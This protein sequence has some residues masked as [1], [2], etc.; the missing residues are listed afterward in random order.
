MR[1]TKL[2]ISAFGPYTEEQIIDF[3]L[4][5][6]RGLYLITGDTG[7]G[8]TTIF[9]AIVFALYG[10]ASGSA[11][12]T[13]MLR[14]KNAPASAPTFVELE[15]LNKGKLYKVRRNP[16]YERAAKRGSGTA[17][18]KADAELT[19]PSGEVFSKQK[20]VDSKIVEILGLDREQ[21]MQIAMI[22]QGDFLRL[23]LA[24]TEDRISIFRSIFKTERFRRLQYAVRDDLTK[25]ENEY[26][27]AYGRISTYI[28]GILASEG[29]GLFEA[30]ADFLEGNLPFCEVYEAL[31]KDNGISKQICKEQKEAIDKTE[32]YLAKLNERV[33]KYQELIRMKAECDS[34]AAKYNES[35]LALEN[36]RLAQSKHAERAKEIEELAQNRDRLVKGR[37]YYDRLDA[38]NSSK[39][40]SD[41]KLDKL[42]RENEK[43]SKNIL[44]HKQRKEFLE[45]KLEGMG[46]PDQ[47]LRELNLIYDAA[48]ARNAEIVAL[49]EESREL[50]SVNSRYLEA[51][52]S[53]EA[54][55]KRTQDKRDIYNA[56]YNGFLSGQAGIIATGL[57]EGKPCPVCGSL[58]HPTPAAL[59]E[60][61]PS[62]KEIKDLKFDLDVEEGEANHLSRVCAKLNGQREKSSAHLSHGI[63][64]VF[65]SGVSLDTNALCEQARLSE[66]KMNEAFQNSESVRL[67]CAEIAQAKVHILGCT[68]ELEKLEKALV[69]TQEALTDQERECSGLQASIGELLKIVDYSAK[70]EAEQKIVEASQ[71]IDP[72]RELNEKL[73]LD[74]EAAQA[75]NLRDE[76][77]LKQITLNIKA[78]EDATDEKDVQMAKAVAEELALKREV[79]SSLLHR[80]SNNENAY[81][82]LCREIS[83]MREAEERLK[84]MRALYATAS[85]GNLSGGKVQFETYILT[86]Y[87][88]RITRRANIRLMKMSYGRYELVRDKSL[89][90]RCQSGL[91][92]NVIDHYSGTERSARSLSGGESFM[93]SLALALGLSEEIQSRSGGI[94]LDAL[95][96]D[97]GFGSLDSQTLDMAVNAL[98]SVAEGN[99]LVGIISHVD[100]LKDRI[101]RKIVVKKESSGQSRAF[102]DI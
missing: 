29:D 54:Q 2:K 46:D 88:D 57:E 58:H 22:A 72:Y 84:W 25:C 4:L 60:A 8:K 64:R 45:K 66:E 102:L 32:A 39:C 21:F 9:D 71:I 92:L 77:A 43:I 30:I 96:V 78:L 99:R 36:A 100:R 65:G 98:M 68:L 6:E 90:T 35:K 86:N 85:G 10:E 52:E 31:S 81:S 53:F 33:G 87:F 49:A 12:Q 76:S 26:R 1:P 70:S 79:Y 16:E 27:D 18:Q 50:D 74:I 7:A 37:A 69:E 73:C 55:L 24:S 44:S 61:F 28:E 23:L 83:L 97:E 40:L 14:S 42:R 38:L 47:K 41:E 89:D 20:E 48:R 59:G 17:R 15:F 63:A 67:I 34:A 94:R 75:E 93:A 82:G 62:E 56:K 91:D 3:E 5:G 101:D 13:S 11:R 51:C 19:L 95:F 80:I